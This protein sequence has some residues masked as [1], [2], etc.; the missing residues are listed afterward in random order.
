MDFKHLFTFQLDNN[1]ITELHK[2]IAPNLILE[3]FDTVA[4]M[5]QIAL[6]YKGID[7]VIDIL[8]EDILCSYSLLYSL[9]VVDSEEYETLKMELEGILEA[10]VFE[11]ICDEYS[12]A[13]FSETITK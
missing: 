11:L 1:M 10:G 6:N 3:G 7:F 9:F 12:K 2:K 13:R 5:T 4:E 8:E